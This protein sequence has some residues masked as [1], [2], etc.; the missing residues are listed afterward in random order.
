MIFKEFP[1]KQQKENV[2]QFPK[3]LLSRPWSMRDSKFGFI[4]YKSDMQNKSLQE[5]V[6]L[7]LYLWLFRYLHSTKDHNAFTKSS[8]SLTLTWDGTLKEVKIVPAR[9]WV[10]RWQQPQLPPQEKSPVRV[11][12]FFFHYI[13]WFWSFSVIARSSVLSPYC[14]SPSSYLWHV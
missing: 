10:G 11:V 7:K 13:A 12:P 2:S 14:C 6:S 1:L 5:S 9:V 4:S 8:N 3:Q